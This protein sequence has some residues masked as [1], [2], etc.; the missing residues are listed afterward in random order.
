MTT[1]PTI[2]LHGLKVSGHVHR[3]ELLLSMLNLPFEFVQAG[4]EVRA[5]EAFRRLN[6]Y[7]QIPVLQDGEVT[8]A[9]STAILVY[10]A[11]RYGRESAW[12]PEDALGAAAVQR[13]LSI[14]SGELAYGPAHARAA[15]L[16]KA[17]HDVARAQAVAA[18]VLGFMETHLHE[19]AYLAAPHATIADLACYAYVAHAP[20]G[21]VLLDPFPQVRAWLRR[22][23]SLPGFVPM[24][25]SPIAA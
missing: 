20:E 1:S 4:A 15:R 14:A 19:R 9:D 23:E 13:W 18:R 25:A 2:L 12:L 3:V 11:K 7:G 10:L 17:P 8:L 6:P 5:T 22:I 24:P 21:G 16:F